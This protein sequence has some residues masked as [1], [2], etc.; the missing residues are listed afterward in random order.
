[1]LA[2]LVAG[3]GDEATAKL[4]ANCFGKMWMTTEDRAKV[5]KH[6]TDTYKAH[7]DK[8]GYVL[9]SARNVALKDETYDG[10]GT[11]SGK[12]VRT[13]LYSDAKDFFQSVSQQTKKAFDATTEKS[14]DRADKLRTHLQAITGTAKVDYAIRRSS[15]DTYTTPVT[16]PDELIRQVP[17]L[18]KEGREKLATALPALDRL[19]GGATGG[20]R[21]ERESI[22]S[23]DTQ[24]S[25]EKA[26]R[27]STKEDASFDLQNAASVLS[28]PE[29]HAKQQ[30]AAS[31]AEAKVKAE[32]VA[33]ERAVELAKAREEEVRSREAWEVA[34]REAEATRQREADEAQRKANET[35]VLSTAWDTVKGGNEARLPELVSGLTKFGTDSAPGREALD[36]VAQR[37]LTDDTMRKAL[38][39]IA[40]KSKEERN[41]VTEATLKAM[42]GDSSGR[43]FNM[44]M[45]PTLGA[46]ALNDKAMLGKSPTEIVDELK[47]ASIRSGNYNALLVLA[48]VACATPGKGAPEG[49]VDRTTAET[50]KRAAFALQDTGALADRKTAVLGAA[51]KVYGRY[52]PDSALKPESSYLLNAIVNVYSRQTA[53]YGGKAEVPSPEPGPQSLTSLHSMLGSLNFGSDS[54]SMG[55]SGHLNA[56]FAPMLARLSTGVVDER[57]A[58][59][60]ADKLEKMWLTGGDRHSAFGDVK[61][62]FARHGDKYGHATRAMEGI[63]S[64]DKLYDYTAFRGPRIAM[65]R[66]GKDTLSEAASVGASKFAA[67]RPDDAARGDDLKEH[68]RFLNARER[69][70]HRLDGR[71]GIYPVVIPDELTSSIPKLSK[72]T[73]DVLFAA[74]PLLE[75]LSKPG[76]HSQKS[77]RS[78]FNRLVEL[79]D[80][81]KADTGISAKETAEFKEFIDERIMAVLGRGELARGIG[82]S[83]PEMDT[84]SRARAFDM[85]RLA[86]RLETPEGARTATP[87]QIKSLATY[88]VK[89]GIPGGADGPLASVLQHGTDSQSKKSAFDYF[90]VFGWAPE[91]G[92]SKVVK[93]AVQKYAKDYVKANPTDHQ[94]IHDASRMVDVGEKLPL[95]VLLKQLGIDHNNPEV[96]RNLGKAIE[97]SGEE[98]VRQA[99][100]N[101]VTW[102]AM[103]RVLRG[104]MLHGKEPPIKLPEGFPGAPK[105]KSEDTTSGTKP[106]S[107][108]KGFGGPYGT[109]Y[110][111]TGGF[112]GASTDTEAARRSSLNPFDRIGL[113]EM[114]HD[115]SDKKNPFSFY[116]HQVTMKDVMEEL[117]SKGDRYLDVNGVLSALA[118]H[119]TDVGDFPDS[120]ADVASVVAS[121]DFGDRLKE[122]GGYFQGAKKLVQS[123]LDREAKWLDTSM[124]S[125]VRTAK[126]GPG[127]FDGSKF[128]HDQTKGVKGFSSATGWANLYGK[129]LAQI[130]SHLT[131]LDFATRV[132]TYTGHVAHGRRG[133]ADNTATDMVKKHGLTAIQAHAPAVFSDIY[134]IDPNSRA[135]LRTASD[136]GLVGR[137]ER[138]G[139]Q[140][141]ALP[142]PAYQFGKPAVWNQGLDVLKTVKDSS[143]AV[144][145]QPMRDSAVEAMKTDPR[146]QSVM[147]RMGALSSGMNEFNSLFPVAA[148]G[149]R[150]EGLTEHMR[151]VG[152]CMTYDLNDLSSNQNKKN[153]TDMLDS[154]KASK[155]PETVALRNS[156]LAIKKLQ[157]DWTQT[158]SRG[159]KNGQIHAMLT[160]VSSSS[161]DANNWGNWMRNNAGWI[162]LEAGITAALLVTTG[163]A[164]GAARAAT[165]GARAVQGITQAGRLTVSMAVADAAV[166]ELKYFSGSATKGHVI[167]DATRAELFGRGYQIDDSGKVALAP[168]F[169]EA[170]KDT[171]KHLAHSFDMNLRLMGFG[172]LATS[173]FNRMRPGMTEA[174]KE[175]EALQNT[176]SKAPVKAQLAE[177]VF[178]EFLS[179]NKT[180]A[181]QGGLAAFMQHKLGL[182]E[183]NAGHVAGY[184]I[185]GKDAYRGHRVARR[186]LEGLPSASIAHSGSSKELAE[187][188]RKEGSRVTERDGHYYVNVGKFEVKLT[189]VPSAPAT[190][191]SGKPYPTMPGPAEGRRDTHGRSHPD[192]GGRPLEHSGGLDRKGPDK[193]DGWNRAFEEFASTWKDT[194]LEPNDVAQLFQARM[195][196]HETLEKRAAELK[197]PKTTTEHAM[198]AARVE[199]ERGVGAHGQALMYYTGASTQAELKA[200]SKTLGVSTENLNGFISARASRERFLNE[201][202]DELRRE[203]KLT[204]EDA[205]KMALGEQNTILAWAQG[206]YSKRTAAIGG[207]AGV[208]RINKALSERPTEA[209]LDSRTRSL[210]A[211][212]RRLARVADVPEWTTSLVKMQE[213]TN[214]YY[215]QGKG[216]LALSVGSLGAKENSKT[217]RTYLA[218]EVTHY[219]HD[220]QIVR[221]LSQ[222]LKDGGIDVHSKDGQKRLQDL[223]FKETGARLESSFAERVLNHKS[224]RNTRLTP[225]EIVSAREIAA[226]LKELTI[227]HSKSRDHT[228]TIHAERA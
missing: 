71:G 205:T 80:A 140:S 82:L 183:E 12:H 203:K 102:N 45:L 202:V 5:F 13:Q 37:A 224:Y 182:S 118:G 92:D 84:A 62:A 129:Q 64:T 148:Q 38:L 108:E 61:H 31:E 161:F 155:D 226:S 149:K 3:A 151:R 165:W 115:S 2:K 221:A 209:L 185:A 25:M 206:E 163:P 27:P 21:A 218:H 52:A 145:S 100:T 122:V 175:L 171:G 65:Q 9:E 58:K 59:R 173:F 107:L 114:R 41:R 191:D 131:R 73:Q 204:Q 142:I 124:R 48:R 110:G 154:L 174:L 40:E 136:T 178:S 93:D 143:T 20:T 10:L 89:T 228:R 69:M 134:G 67:R 227:D 33:R 90:S 177:A 54:R 216:E 120:R 125:I 96:K 212:F 105:T 112:L 57:S 223:Y 211:F 94:F 68:F 19:S 77:G 153:V 187:F 196:L 190:V 164:G 189:E 215:Q 98:R 162:A 138:A 86:Q 16:L 109:K 56:E 201:R 6:L 63:S 213:G 166:R 135:A 133:D 158:D 99:L 111:T 199:A 200:L 60:S 169:G 49:S 214:G 193:I 170:A 152:A 103:D 88:C 7:G 117:A 210:D 217:L 36:F 81:V 15:V 132:Q 147:A 172:H 146:F 130:D 157:D 156:L 47:G 192:E 74:S 116:N 104:A 17:S 35:K 34:K 121:R 66:E 167:G 4:A 1:M 55:S 197:T 119:R 11:R 30:K 186:A 42:K 72:E 79:S 106:G 179:L 14:P 180:N 95:P 220:I 46:L 28:L 50:G 194:G 207:P 91:T 139:D 32:L 24:L 144:L 160:H 168:T 83:L 188:L 137:L 39:S 113:H 75:R 219:E 53:T 97:K 43:G 44:K 176:L 159:N 51:A 225:A 29:D 128:E 127:F 76:D 26:L 150:S 101:L 126:E 18:S 123:S 195:H 70:E 22:A 181:M 23:L 78:D 141:A 87:E 222:S 85:V 8:H 198:A 208:E 184:L